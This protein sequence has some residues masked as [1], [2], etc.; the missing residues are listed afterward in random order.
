MLLSDW[1]ADNWNALDSGDKLEFPPRLGHPRT[2]G[3]KQLTFALP[4]GQAQDWGM[5]L[6]DG[7]RLH[8]HEFS[9][10]RLIVHRDKYDPDRGTEALI[11]HLVR[12]IPIGILA[13]LTL[14]VAAN[15]N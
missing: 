3:F 10:G 2:L 7:S 4:A 11:A 15:R 8:V 6:S 9:D 5:P 13:A 1:L 14:V 12:E